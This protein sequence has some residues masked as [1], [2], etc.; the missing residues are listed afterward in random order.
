[1][2]TEIDAVAY[3]VYVF[4]QPV[5]KYPTVQLAEA[6]ILNL[7]PAHQVLAEIVPVQRDTGK[8]LLC[9]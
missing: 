2:I 1:M 3:A 7:S 6:A 4:G 5:A 8:Q 9:G